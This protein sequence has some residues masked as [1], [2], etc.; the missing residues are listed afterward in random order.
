[1]D[2]PYAPPVARIDDVAP[3]AD[4][5]P[6][7]LKKIRQAWIAGTVSTTLTLVFTVLALAGTSLL[8]FTGWDIV[9]VLVM[10]ALTFGIYKRSR[11][12]AVAMLIYF[13]LSKALLFSATGKIN[14]I[15]MALI[16][17]YYYVRGVAG[18]FAYRKFLKDGSAAV[19]SRT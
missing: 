18:T 19:Q 9:D 16:F 5:P 8:G 17:F 15:F 6:P 13:I 7:I 14:G 1:M 4:V 11:A 2:N 3:L 12:C 10:A